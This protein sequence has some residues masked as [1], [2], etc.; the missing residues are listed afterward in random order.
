MTKEET[1]QGTT[2]HMQELS[3]DERVTEIAQMLSGSDVTAAAV[4]NAKVLLKQKV[5]TVLLLLMTVLNINAA[6][7]FTGTQLAFPGADGYG[8]YTSGGRGGEVCYVTSLDD[9]TDA[10]LV[11]GTVTAEGET[12]P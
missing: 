9:C 8:K 3:A 11:A 2:S 7:P 5:L 10:N 4:Q 1:P 12:V 6:E